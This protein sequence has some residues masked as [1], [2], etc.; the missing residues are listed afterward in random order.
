[1]LQELKGTKAFKK[2]SPDVRDKIAEAKLVFDREKSVNS[3]ELERLVGQ[4]VLYGKI[5]QLRHPASGLFL[6]VKRTAAS[7]DRGAL[8]LVLSSGHNASWFQIVSGTALQR[9]MAL[10]PDQNAA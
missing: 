5:V 3:Q 9:C 4:P 1:M 6:T 7:V 2:L 10:H 8:R